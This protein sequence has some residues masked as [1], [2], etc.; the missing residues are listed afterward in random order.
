MNKKKKSKLLLGLL[1]AVVALGVGYAA[2]T[3]VNLL[4]NGTSSVKSGDGDFVVRFV[5]NIASETAIDNPVENAIKI[6]GKNAD[7]SAMDVSGMSATVVDDTHA[8]F[9]A[10]E[11]DEVGEYVEFTYTVVNESD[12]IDA[13]LSFDVADENDAEQYFEITKVADKSVIGE[14]ETTNVKVKVKLMY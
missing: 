2:I 10:G 4:I 8:T 13:M 14:N 3:G 11:L 6:S 9:S 12:D 1:I 7:D 5:K